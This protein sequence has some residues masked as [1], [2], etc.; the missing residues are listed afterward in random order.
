MKAYILT[1]QHLHHWIDGNLKA[2][3]IKE[4]E[5]AEIGETLYRHKFNGDSE[6]VTHCVVEPLGVKWAERIAE[7]EKE[8]AEL[9]KVV[10]EAVE[11]EKKD[12]AYVKLLEERSEK[13]GSENE[14]LKR[15]MNDS[16]NVGNTMNDA[17][18]CLIKENAELRNQIN[19]LGNQIATGNSVCERMG[20][21]IENLSASCKAKDSQIAELKDEN[22]DIRWGRQEE[23]ESF[24]KDLNI[25]LERATHYRDECQKAQAEI[26]ELRKINT[27]QAEKFNQVYTDLFN[28]NQ[29]LRKGQVKWEMGKGGKAFKAVEKCTNYVRVY[30][31]GCYCEIPLPPVEKDAFEQWWETGPIDYPELKGP[32]WV[33]RAAWEAAKEGSK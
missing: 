12:I 10:D 13:L 1:D 18:G 25:E 14:K 16:I 28:E 21:Q 24:K 4:I 26:A 3:H 17:Y 30:L 15:L 2:G 23:Y 32:E 9:K 11:D 22:R 20:K 5:V 29:E 31:D 8:N 6:P 7:L 19:D 33:A 27:E